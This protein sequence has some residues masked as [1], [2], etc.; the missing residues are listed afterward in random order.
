MIDNNSAI[1]APFSTQ[2]L[3]VFYGSNV[4]GI[5]YIAGMVNSNGHRDSW[6]HAGQNLAKPAEQFQS[7]DITF[8]GLLALGIWA[9]AV[10]SANV[11]A[12]IP[13]GVLAGLHASRIDGANLAGLRN[14]VAD[15]QAQAAQLQQNNSVLLQRFALTE[16]ANGE[17]TRRVGALELS[18]PKLVEAINSPN[19][20][21]SLDGGTVTGS[22]SA[23]SPVTTF[24][25]DG[26][27]VSYTTTPLD[28]Q[29]GPSARQGGEQPM[30]RALDSMAQPDAAA[31]G[32][33]LGAPIDENEGEDAWQSMNTRVGTLLLGLAPI[34][35]RVEGSS[36]RRLVVGPLDTEAGAN[37]LCG[38]MAKIGIAC[39]TVPFIGEPLPLTN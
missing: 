27:S 3:P 8:W 31:F 35:G 24:A 4:L 32:V 6:R 20:D 26:G 39:A 2:D 1:Y 30:P 16:Q 28:G 13:P 5:H 25:A 9:F 21:S 18:M 12:L 15:L 7:R 33:A 14:Q 10:L 23:T 19:A 37:E 29:S 11:S 22:T 34:L 36:G 38:R 17:V